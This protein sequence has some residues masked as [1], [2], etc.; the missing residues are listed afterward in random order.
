[1]LPWIRAEARRRFPPFRAERLLEATDGFNV[2]KPQGNQDGVRSG[3]DSKLRP[4]RRVGGAAELARLSD[5]LDAPARVPTSIVTFSQDLGSGTPLRWARLARLVG[6]DPKAPIIVALS[7]GADSVFLLHLIAASLDRPKLYAVHIDHGLRGEESRGDAEFCARLSAGLGIPFLRRRV[8]LDP[9]A[10]DLERLAREARYRA[11]AEEARALGVGTIATGHH[12]DDALETLMIRWMRG[13][14]LSGLAGLKRRTLL[15]PN[16]GS[17]ADAAPIEVVRPMIDLRQAEIREELSRAC[18]AWREDSSNGSSRFT[19]NRIRNH[20]LP[21][22]VRSGGSSA[23]ENLRAFHAAIEH[24]ETEL[25]AQTAH[26][27]WRPPAFAAASRSR[28]NAHLGGSLE[29]RR[30]MALPSPLRRRTLWRLLSE[31]CGGAPSRQLLESLLAD[32]ETGRCG[33]HALHAGWSLQLRSD[34]LH[35]SPPSLVLPEPSLREEHEPAHQLVLPFQSE[36][37]EGTGAAQLR[38]PGIVELGDG[39]FLSAESFELSPGSAFP[40]SSIEVELEAPPEGTP[41]WVRLPRPG[42]KFHGLGAPGSKRLSRFLADA[43]LPR[44]DRS[45][46]PL[47]FFGDELAWV[48]GVRPCERYRVRP[49]TI[50]RLRLRLHEAAPSSVSDD[51]GRDLFLGA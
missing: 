7:G 20:W 51:R 34:L 12:A 38:V 39:R 10:P 36:P 11:L 21:E 25:A 9:E 22:V 14:E 27:D 33:R 19:R 40:R 1:M 16:L 8:E 29:R 48:A 35:L 6:V 24:F 32:L 23:L 26:I 37:L 5:R 2:S 44:E 3:R 42:D 18:I 30:L 17:P 49:S 46:V 41:L 28:E 4:R 13:T 15:G 43:G 50:E 31:G 47:V 45:R